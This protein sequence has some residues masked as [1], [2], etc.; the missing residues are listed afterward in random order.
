V[1]KPYGKQLWKGL[2]PFARTRDVEEA[3]AF[4]QRHSE[5]PVI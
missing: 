4:Y 1:D 5:T 3:I 2:P